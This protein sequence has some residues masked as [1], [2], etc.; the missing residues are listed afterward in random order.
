[1]IRNASYDSV[2]A[3]RGKTPSVERSRI[4]DVKTQRQRQLGRFRTIPCWNLARLAVTALLAVLWASADHAMCVPLPA[5]S[6]GPEDRPPA[7]SV[8]AAAEAERS[9]LAKPTPGR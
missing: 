8:L 7:A 4:A 2:G 1:M 3:S 5:A 6:P 9:L